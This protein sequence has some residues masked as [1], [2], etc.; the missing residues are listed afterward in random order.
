MPCDGDHWDQ[1]FKGAMFYLTE[2]LDIRQNTL[3]VLAAV[4]EAQQLQ[5]R[6]T[7]AA[8][9][10]LAIGPGFSGNVS[11]GTWDSPLVQTAICEAA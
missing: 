6:C 1:P 5:I 4:I 11:R 10:A 3:V 9:A 8:L 2:I 7:I